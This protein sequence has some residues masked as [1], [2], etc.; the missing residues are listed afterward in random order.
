MNEAILRNHIFQEFFC[1][2]LKNNFILF[3][4]IFYYNFRITKSFNPN[5]SGHKNRI[6]NLIS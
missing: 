1:S 4:F 2:L 3:I 5:D 6:Y